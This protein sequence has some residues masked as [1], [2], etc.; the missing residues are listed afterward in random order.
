M[1]ERREPAEAVGLY[2]APF[3]DGPFLSDAPEF[4]RWVTHGRERLAGAYG[5]ALESLA[6]GAEAARDFP[7]AVEWWKRRAAQDPYDSRVAARLIKSLDQTGNRA[8]AVQHASIHQR[9]LHE[10]MGIAASPEI[11]TL[12]ERLRRDPAPGAATIRQ[13][14]MPAAGA[15]APPA[16]GAAR[17]ICPDGPA[18]SAPR[19]SRPPLRSAA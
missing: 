19:S 2:T 17:K 5:K 4:E 1:I 10:E 15:E 6:E 14:E 3:L 12:V 9:L 16:L 18:G 8:G 7:R 13:P 11:T